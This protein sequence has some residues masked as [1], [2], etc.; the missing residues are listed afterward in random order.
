MEAGC[1]RFRSGERACCL[2]VAV[3]DGHRFASRQSIA[4]CG[5]FAC[6]KG[7]A[8]TKSYTVAKK[9]T[10][11]KG[12]TG[13]KDYARASPVRKNRSRLDLVFRKL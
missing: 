7:F 3:A 8:V 1:R 11:T 2:R 10:G 6:A 9:H 5:S 12:Y 13:T 4:G